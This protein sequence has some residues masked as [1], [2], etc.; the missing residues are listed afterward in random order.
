MCGY[1]LSDSGKND[2]RFAMLEQW[3]VL[4]YGVPSV[5]IVYES[6]AQRSDHDTLNVYRSTLKNQATRISP[7][8]KRTSIF[9]SASSSF[10]V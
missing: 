9:P 2:L 3:T 4:E 10:L 1:S 7:V 8:D 5:Y 6:D